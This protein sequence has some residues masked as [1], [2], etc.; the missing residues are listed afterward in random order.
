MLGAV[1]EWGVRAAWKRTAGT[2]ARLGTTG[3]AESG[4]TPEAVDMLRSAVAEDAGVAFVTPEA[5]GASPRCA[6]WSGSAPEARCGTLE[7][8][9]RK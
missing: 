2:G 8:R 7:W 6:R 4:A 5:R 3:Q 9:A 1:G